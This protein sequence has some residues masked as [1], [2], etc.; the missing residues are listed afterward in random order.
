[1]LDHED[2]SMFQLNI[3][4]RDHG[5]PRRVAYTR[6]TVNVVDINDNSPR[7]EYPIYNATV[8]ENTNFGTFVTHIQASDADAGI[9]AQL[10]YLIPSGL[11]ES[12]FQINPNTGD[13]STNRTLDR[14]SAGSWILTAYVKDGAYPA[15]YDSTT[16]QITVLDVNDNAP[17][18]QNP[19]YYLDVPENMAID[20]FHT[21]V[22]EDPDSGLNG[23]ITYSITGKCLMDLAKSDIPLRTVLA[24][25]FVMSS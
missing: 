8:Q 15:L 20:L 9:N 7:F 5:F 18:F 3:S 11:A 2:V 21:V 1:M 4:A 24:K 25:R 13:I 17:V 23:T 6:L 22:A 14:E 16:V 19:H 10:T 12:N